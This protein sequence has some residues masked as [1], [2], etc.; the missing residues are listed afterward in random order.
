MSYLVNYR[1]SIIDIDYLINFKGEDC[2]ICQGCHTMYVEYKG[3]DSWFHSKECME[4]YFNPS[5]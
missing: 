1:G 4:K 3:Y 5:N 2:R